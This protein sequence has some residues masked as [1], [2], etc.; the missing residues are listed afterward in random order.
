MLG[1]GDGVLGLATAAMVLRTVPALVPGDIAR[2]DQVGIDGVTLA[3]TLG[4][5]IAAGLLFG[6]VPALLW[7]RVDLTRAER[8]QRAIHRRFRA[9]SPAVLA[10]DS[11]F[12]R[13]PPSRRVSNRGVV[14]IVTVSGDATVILRIESVI[15]STPAG[16]SPLGRSWGCRN[17]Q[18]PR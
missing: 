11:S 4:L 2:L 16:R 6:A 14:V 3:F 7:S 5:S 10:D 9:A 18:P 15:R 1:V 8:G 13:P 12:R 17:R